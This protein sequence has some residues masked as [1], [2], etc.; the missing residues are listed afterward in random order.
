[1]VRRLLVLAALLLYTSNGEST[2]SLSPNESTTH[3]AVPVSI[4]NT[5]TKV[6]TTSSSAT[7]LSSLVALNLACS[8][9]EY[10][11]DLSYSSCFDAMNQIRE[12]TQIRTV[13]DR[14]LRT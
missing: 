3:T 10:G 1:M 12:D 11:D 6:N 2:L 8:S 4:P 7:N 9:S 13:G 14:N 5:I